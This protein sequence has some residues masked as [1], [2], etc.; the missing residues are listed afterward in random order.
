MVQIAFVSIKA[1]NQIINCAINV[2]V[3]KRC[4]RNR[5]SL[6]RSRIS[7]VIVLKNHIN[8]PISGKLN[9]L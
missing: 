7:P 5:S 8:D 6:F 1:V 9:N 2:I 3:N 4:T